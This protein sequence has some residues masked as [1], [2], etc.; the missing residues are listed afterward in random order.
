METTE[1]AQ[2]ILEFVNKAFNYS[3]SPEEEPKFLNSLM[4][5]C[6]SKY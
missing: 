6:G 4:D 1:D 2:K 3:E 5:F